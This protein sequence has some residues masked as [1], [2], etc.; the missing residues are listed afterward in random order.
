[1]TAD[2]LNRKMW[3]LDAPLRLVQPDVVVAGREGFDLLPFAVSQDFEDDGGPTFK[4][5]AHAFE[6]LDFE[7]FNVDLDEVNL[8]DA[9]THSECVEANH[10]NLFTHGMGIKRIARRRH[11]VTGDEVNRSSTFTVAHRSV[12][13]FN[14][15]MVESAVVGKVFVS[16]SNRLKAINLSPR[17]IVLCGEGVE[18]DVC[19]DIEYDLRACRQFQ[20]SPYCLSFIR[21]KAAPED[22]IFNDV[23]VS[24]ENKTSVLY[25]ERTRRINSSCNARRE[26]RTETINL[27][28]H[29]EVLLG[30]DINISEENRKG[31]NVVILRGTNVL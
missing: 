4:K 26:N 16:L 10:P 30:T 21:E 13:R 8:P 18:A 20:P 9:F 3:N 6:H 5:S 19:A 11:D 15:E 24:A 25:S 28:E 17:K 29:C 12:N 14:V 27:R 7:S 23:P 31:P 2:T 22:A 1:M